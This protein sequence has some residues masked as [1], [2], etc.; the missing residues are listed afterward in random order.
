[1]SDDDH[2]VPFDIAQL[3]EIVHGSVRLGTLAYLSTAGTVGFPELKRQLHTTDGNLTTHLRKLADAGYVSIDKHGAGRASLTRITLTP[4]GQQ[5]FLAY[6]D[7]M[8]RLARQIRP[9]SVR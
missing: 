2:P 9:D 5:A 3:D 1:M 6:L 4:S 8:T 7:T